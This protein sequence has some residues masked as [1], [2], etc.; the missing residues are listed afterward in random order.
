LEEASILAII[1]V[2]SGIKLHLLSINFFITAICII[3]LIF[4]SAFISGTEVAFFSLSPKEIEHLKENKKDSAVLKLLEKPN[5]LLATI[6]IINNFINVAIVILSA[7]LTST[8]ISFPQGSNLEFLFQVVIITSLLVLFGEITPKI[9]ANANARA[10]ASKASIFI[11]FFQKI[12]YPFSYL[13]VSTTNIIDKR[14]RKRQAEASFEDISKALDLTEKE[15]KIE[16]RR[17]LRS[18]VEFGNT[19]VKEIMK[20]RLDVFAIEEKLG[21]K[22]VLKNIISSGFSRIP[23]YR[24]Q[25]DNILGILYIKDLIP[26]LNEGDTFKWFDLCRDAYFV[27]ETKMINDLLKEFQIK[28]NH[29]AIVVDEYGGTSGIVTLEDILEEIVGEIND[30]FDID[31]NIYSKLDDKNY[32]FEGKISL[33]DFLKIVKGNHDFFDDIK[34]E[35]DSLAGLVLE[36]KGKI[37]KIGDVCRI[38]P[39]TIIVESSDNRRIRRLKVTLDEN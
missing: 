33:I 15:S 16:E 8:V 30:E 28:K 25:F 7:Y 18:I 11:L 22:E 19:D 23:I 6:L 29:I 13:L 21:F 2:F 1:S 39:Y 17:M 4:A 10:F 35:S 24:D 37:P 32:I 12:I 26:Y 14:L 20:S 3:A 27:P 9:Y 31:D 5:L 34:G 36:H 38:P